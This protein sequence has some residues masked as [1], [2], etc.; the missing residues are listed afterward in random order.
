[1]TTHTSHRL[2]FASTLVVAL[3]L[4]AVAAAEGGSASKQ[5]AASKEQSASTQL[6]ERRSEEAT[7]LS[8]TSPEQI[9]EMQRQ[10]AARNLYT[11][12]ID[13][14]VGSQT[15]KALENFQTQQGMTATG[16]LDSRTADALGI[17][18]YD[19]QP[20]SGS[21][22]P[23]MKGTQTQQP[24]QIQHQAG[25]ETTVPLS[26]IGTED[27]RKIQQ[28]LQE[29]GFYN[30]PIDGVLGQQTRGALSRYYQRQAQLAAQGVLSEGVMESFGVSAARQPTSGSEP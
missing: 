7:R 1:M 21:D 22:T 2:T 13:G 14:V 19:R 18:G 8:G 23:Q 4:P 9:K 30:G 20:V 12:K 5:Y 24:S 11:G 28:R 16:Q 6:K 25:A 26:S 29:L 3:G 17:I 27:G 15:Q 10:L